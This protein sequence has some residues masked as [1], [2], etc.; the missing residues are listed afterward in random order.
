MFS[1]ATEFIANQAFTS[2]LWNIAESGVQR[3]EYLVHNYL[4]SPTAENGMDTQKQSPSSKKIYYVS[5]NQDCTIL[6]VGHDDGYSFYNLRSLERLEK[7]SDS[8][9]PE[10]ACIVE[11][12]YSSSLTCVVSMKSTRKLQVFHSKNENE[13][14][15]HTYAS[16]I[17]AVRMNRKRVVVCLED[18]IHIH[19]IRDMKIMHMLKDTPPNPNGIVDLSIADSNCFLAFPCS[20][21][22]GHVHIFDAENLNTVCQITAHDGVLAAIRFNPEGN[23]M[24]TASE[25]GT[26]IRVFSIPDGERLYEFTRGVTRYAQINSLAFSQDS[27]FLCLSSNTETVHLFALLTPFEQQQ[28][29]HRHSQHHQCQKSD[30]TSQEGLSSWVSYLSQ[31]ASA[32]LPQHVNELMLREKSTATARLPILGTRTVVAIPRIQGIDY[33]MVASQ[34]GYLFC[35]SMPSEG[36][37]ECN[38]MRQFRI[39]ADQQ[40]EGAVG[41]EGCNAEGTP[42]SIRSGQRHSRASESEQPKPSTQTPT[43]PP[44]RAGSGGGSSS[45]LSSASAA[46]VPATTATAGTPAA[47]QHSVPP[48]PPNPPK[49]NTPPSKSSTPVKE[50][51][52]ASANP[53]DMEDMLIAPLEDGGETDL[54]YPDMASAAVSD[55]LHVVAPPADLNDLDEYPPL[56]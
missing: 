27:R 16:S 8:R 45:S 32:Y 23:K 49:R 2:A 56:A 19:N 22:T 30:E 51:G 55:H 12:L 34:E 48:L 46:P 52:R 42:V 17:I 39:S 28:A 53:F 38:L 40:Q 15:S 37:T 50:M 10:R 41:D 35:Y 26:V 43:R 11:K 44:M 1:G 31:Q 13:I 33:L 6:V 47:K 18:T 3:A 5:F 7:I 14:C 4:L 21:S 9:V 25:K 24:A 29:Y 20:S 54:L 36:S